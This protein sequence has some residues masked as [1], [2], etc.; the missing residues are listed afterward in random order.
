MTP[1]SADIDVAARR[2]KGRIRQIPLAAMDPS[3]RDIELLLKLENHQ[4]A[5]SFK[6]RGAL[7]AALAACERGPLPAGL[8]TFSSGNHGQAVALAAAEIGVPAVVVAPTDVRPTKLAAMEARGA[9]V[10]LHGLTSR[11]RMERA[12]EMAASD[13][14]LLIPPYDHPDVI[15]GQG[16]I[17]REI[18]FEAPAPFVV[19]VPIGGG[20]LSAGICLALSR[21][22]D[23]RVIGVEPE[24]A[25]DARR[26]LAAGRIVSNERASTSACDGLRNTR[27]GDLNFAI[28]RDHLSEIVSVS[29]ADVAEAQRALERA[30]HGPVEPS[31][32][33]AV[34]AVLA[35]QAGRPGETVVCVVSGGNA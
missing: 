20:G 9:R 21:R 6:P 33:A 8:I 5:G 29:E 19:V 1:A 32:A 35:G 7:N 26:S 4:H 3:G 27:M 24:D 15:A 10:I 18:A 23:V 31:G 16:T 30:G 12:M 28:L 34:A 25:D 13:G 14:L 11:E 17:G 2:L 22:D